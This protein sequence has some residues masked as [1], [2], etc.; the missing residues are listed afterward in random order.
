[1]EYVGLY[2]KHIDSITT[3]SVIK[4][5][6]SFISFY[7]I[8]PGSVAIFGLDNEESSN[9]VC[10]YMCNERLLLILWLIWYV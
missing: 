3:D 8:F 5:K 7:F 6:T 4:E 2:G 10:M 1:M 9:S